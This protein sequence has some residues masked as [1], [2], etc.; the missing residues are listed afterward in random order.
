MEWYR[1]EQPATGPGPIGA[2]LGRGAWGF[3]DIRYQGESWYDPSR[4]FGAQKYPSSADTR[5][6]IALERSLRSLWSPSWPELAKADVLPQIKPELADEGREIYLKYNCGS[7]HNAPQEAPKG[8][9]W[10][11][12]DG[13]KITDKFGTMDLIETDGGMAKN[14][15]EYCGT[16]TGPPVEYNS[17]RMKTINLSQMLAVRLAAMFVALSAWST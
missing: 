7:C 14:A 9:E 15:I 4:V 12:W 5:N 6:L 13:R 10:R 17:R 2:E 11:K 16:N 1:R 8:V 3:R